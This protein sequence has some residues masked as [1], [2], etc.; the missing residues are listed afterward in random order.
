MVG[1]KVTSKILIA[2]NLILGGGYD[3][4]IRLGKG[5]NINMT[6]GT[7]ITR[8]SY[9]RK[10]TKDSLDI[11]VQDGSIWMSQ[12]QLAKLFGVQRPAIARQIGNIYK[13][14]DDYAKYLIPLQVGHI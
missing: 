10:D 4:M 3:I 14:Q 2:N 8:Y 7:N 12:A 13:D 5:T 11:I 1:I 6:T 9:K